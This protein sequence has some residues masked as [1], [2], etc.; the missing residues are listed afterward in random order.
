MIL[1]SGVLSGLKLI[2]LD[3]Y[4][5]GIHPVRLSAGIGISIICAV[6][7]I[8]IYKR[9]V[10]A[11]FVAIAAMIISA[12]VIAVVTLFFLLVGQQEPDIMELVRYGLFLSFF[13]FTFS[14]IF[15]LSRKLKKYFS[16]EKYE[17][18]D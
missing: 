13:L 7:L 4:S 17:N 14:L 12:V 9:K 15:T 2:I 16:H 6:C 3:V 18:D 8:G 10:F 5:W 11:K 1:L